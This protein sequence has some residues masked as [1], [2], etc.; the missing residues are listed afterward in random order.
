M[1]E[2]KPRLQFTTPRGVAVYPYLNTPSTLHN[3]GNDFASVY[4]VDLAFEEGDPEIA[5]LRALLEN[6]AND[7]RESDWGRQYIK[8]AWPTAIPLVEETREDDEGYKHP[9]GRMLLRTKLKQYVS[10]GKGQGLREQ[11]VQFYD[12]EPKLIGVSGD[13]HAPKVGAGSILRVSVDAVPYPNTTKDPAVL[14]ITLYIAGVQI[15]ELVE[16]GHKDPVTTHGLEAISGG[17]VHTLEQAAA[18]AGESTE[19]YTKKPEG[20]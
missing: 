13:A 8:K 2:K 19:D 3:Q 17:Y 1:G 20:M 15:I 5:K 16:W 18:A 4:K 14:Q 9:T 12:T 7:C 6:F 11:R 10:A